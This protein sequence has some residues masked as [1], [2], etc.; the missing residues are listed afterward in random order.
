MEPTKVKLSPEQETLL[1]TLFAKAQKDNPIFFDPRALGVVERIDYDFSA[2]RVPHKTVVLVSQRAKKIDAIASEFMREHPGAVVVH[3]GCGLDARFERIDDG[4][5]E[6]YDLDMSPVIE[7]RKR[8][9]EPRERYHTV[10][11]DAADLSWMDAIHAGGRPVLVIAEGL[12]MYLED[13]DVRRLFVRLRETFPGCRIVGDVF[14]R[15]TARAASRH[16]SLKRTG[17]HIGWGV[18]DAHD[19]ETWGPGIRLLE[20][21]YFTDDPELAKLGPALLLMYRLAGR[22]KAARLAQRIVYYQL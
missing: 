4:A 22:F 2:L 19:V 11:S 1:I 17:A 14:S 20:E 3:I 6:W 15:M 5:V 9:F 10:S 18:D 16:P 7:L 21:W 13:D 8:F 12:L